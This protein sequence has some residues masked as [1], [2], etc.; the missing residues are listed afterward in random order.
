MV[1]SCKKEIN[2]LRKIRYI[3]I[4]EEKGIDFSKSPTSLEKTIM[5]NKI[6]NVITNIPSVLYEEKN[7]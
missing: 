5:L 4:G 7:E 2:A 3:L 6:W 1:L